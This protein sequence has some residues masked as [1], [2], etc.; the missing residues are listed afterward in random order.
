MGRKSMGKREK[1]ENHI[2]FAVVKYVL[3]CIGSAVLLYD[4]WKY[5]GILFVG[6]PFY[7]QRWK[8][9]K[10]G[11][12]QY[13]R[14]MQFK[15]ALMGLGAALE[16]GYSMENAIGAANKDLDCIYPENAW[17]RRELNKISRAAENAV[18]VNEAIQRFAAESGLEDAQSFAQLYSMA[19]KSGGNLMGIIRSAATV[20]ADKAETM[21]EI[22]TILA[23]KQLECRI[24]QLIP[25]G[26]LVYFRI[27]SPGFLGILYDGLRGRI[28]MSCLFAG[29]LFLIRQ[30]ERIV[31]IRV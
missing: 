28:I 30:M 21:R 11:E 12:E 16:A 19:H 31:K 15:D 2:A 22:R 8:K 3:L 20:L 23:A 7:L 17:I 10:K 13:E 1:L 18:P 24:M 5:A 14:S 4:N 29:Y 25:P 6:M 9:K 27:C 26:I